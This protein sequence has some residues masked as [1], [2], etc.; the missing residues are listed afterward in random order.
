MDRHLSQLCACT[1][2]RVLLIVLQPLHSLPLPTCP[3]PHCLLGLG[4]ISW[5]QSLFE[6]CRE[7][8]PAFQQMLRRPSKL[9]LVLN[10]AYPGGQRAATGG[11]GPLPGVPLY[12]VRTIALRV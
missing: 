12:E 6:D 11:A 2:I 5:K 4:L 3:Y 10:E 9:R 7:L 1:Y 8:A